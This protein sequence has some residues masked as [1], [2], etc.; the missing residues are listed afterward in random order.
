MNSKILILSHKKLSNAIYKAIDQLPAHQSEIV[1]KDV[2]FGGL[3]NFLKQKLAQIQPSIIITG[4]AHW[5]MLKDSNI[6]TSIPT[7]PIPITRYDLLSA[8]VEAKTISSKIAIISYGDQLAGLE[9]E[10]L[11]FFAE[12]Y[13][14]KYTSNKEVF[15]I[16]DHLNNEGFGVVIGAGLVCEVSESFDLPSVFLHSQDSVKA[17]IEHVLRIE[18]ARTQMLEVANKW[19]M[20]LIKQPV[21]MN[22]SYVDEALYPTYTIETVSDLSRRIINDSQAHKIEENAHFTIAKFRLIQPLPL[23]ELVEQARNTNVK[24]TF[25]AT[26]HYMYALLIG[27]QQHFVKYFNYYLNINKIKKCGIAHIQ[28]GEI[29]P[30][31]IETA[32]Q[33]AELA[34]NL[35]KNG[36]I[37]VFNETNIYSILSELH[38]SD[39]LPKI[40]LLKPLLE[41]RNKERLI[42]TLELLLDHGLS[43]TTVSNYLGIS[44]QTVYTLM[45]RIE[46]LVGLLSDVNS[47]FLLSLELRIYRLQCA[48]EKTTTTHAIQNQL[49]QKVL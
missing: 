34:Y 6:P 26:D 47:R 25:Y 14:F 21:M 43:I 3:E 11:P 15:K 10:L 19:S 16:F 20:E 5:E 31:S 8:V 36:E 41:Q 44:R 17:V 24:L 46:T 35:A 13:F 12:I 28:T 30:N 7:V 38:K 33:E 2:G 27:N 42:E 48:L 1:I 37:E 32:L 18:E 39:T 9:D 45:K 49:Q 4:G 29:T 23:K 40:Q 22:N